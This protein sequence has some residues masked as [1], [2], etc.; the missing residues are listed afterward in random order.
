VPTVTESRPEAIHAAWVRVLDGGNQD[1]RCIG[2]GSRADAQ[3][4]LDAWLDTH[5]PRHV[6]TYVGP[7]DPPMARK[8]RR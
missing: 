4:Q 2:T 1:W 7:G 5:Q 3:R 8:R 6:E